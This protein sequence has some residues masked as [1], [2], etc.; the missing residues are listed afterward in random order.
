MAR[1]IG[2]KEVMRL[3]SVNG[4]RR[5][6]SPDAHVSKCSAQD[7]LEAARERGVSCEDIEG[8]T[9]DAVFRLLFLTP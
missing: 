7:V 8:M 6:R 5:T 2:T 1:R 3:R 4:L 9:E